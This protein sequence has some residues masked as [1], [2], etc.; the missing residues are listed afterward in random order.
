MQYITESNPELSHHGNCSSSALKCFKAPEIYG[1]S[2]RKLFKLLVKKFC[3]A[4]IY[5]RNQLQRSEAKFIF[6]NKNEINFSKRLYFFILLLYFVTKLK[7]AILMYNL[8]IFKILF[9]YNNIELNK[10]SVVSYLISRFLKC[11]NNDKKILFKKFLK[12]ISTVKS[13]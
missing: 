5:Y 12:K 7:F 3:G 2:Y 8:F 6:G 1:S 13:P 10:F 11:R 9:V 4:V